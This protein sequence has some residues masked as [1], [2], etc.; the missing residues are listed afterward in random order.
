MLIII[1]T[2]S[3]NYDIIQHTHFDAITI[4][5]FM[6]EKIKAQLSKERAIRVCFPFTRARKHPQ[7]FIQ[8]TCIK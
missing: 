2:S 6:K 5:S 4:G 3:N 7:H 1:I 8:C